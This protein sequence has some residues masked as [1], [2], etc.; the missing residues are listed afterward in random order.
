[1]SMCIYK[2]YMSRREI[3]IRAKYK[4][5]YITLNKEYGTPIPDD[6][7]TTQIDKLIADYEVI[8]TIIWSEERKELLRAIES[9]DETPDDLTGDEMIQTRSSLVA[10]AIS[11]DIRRLS[12]MLNDMDGY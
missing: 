12:R 8:T 10:I 1:M 4:S 2:I 7:D 3:R 6:I 11:G 9:I 5:K